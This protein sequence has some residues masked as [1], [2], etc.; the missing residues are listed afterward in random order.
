MSEERVDP[1]FV[2]HFV[3]NV[4]LHAQE[5]KY[6]E[7]RKKWRTWWWD[8]TVVLLW[9]SLTWIHAKTLALGFGI[10][11]IA[12]INLHIQIMLLWMVFVM[13]TQ[14]LCY[15]GRVVNRECNVTLEE[16]I[17]LRYTHIDCPF[18]R[19]YHVYIPK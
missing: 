17:L 5:K 14:T 13:Q 6:F 2:E 4:W 19:K 9:K 1:N 10:F 8:H 16:G 12:I 7:E 15:L 11:I 3:R 18:I